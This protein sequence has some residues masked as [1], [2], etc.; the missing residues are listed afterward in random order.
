MIHPSKINQC[1]TGPEWDKLV[2]TIGKEEAMREWL[3][4]EGM[5]DASLYPK[6]RF[7]GDFEHVWHEPFTIE[8]YS[9]M[10]ARKK[11]LE[12]TGAKVKMSGTGLQVSR[13]P[14]GELV[15]QKEASRTPVDK[16]LDTRVKGFLNS[17]GFEVERLA[18]EGQDFAAMADTLNGI[19]KVVD[20]KAG[21][22]T[23]SHEAT[24]AFLDLLPADS[25]LLADIIKD[26]KTKEEYDQ[27][28]E[29]YKDDPQYKNEDGS[30]NEEKMA[31]E[32]AAHIIDDIIVDK[33]DQRSSMKWWERLWNWIKDMFKGKSL[34][35]Y[36]VVAE[37][38]LAGKTAKLS[39]EKMRKMK[40]ASDK[41]EIYY[42][43][44]PEKEKRYN[45]IKN[46]PE[47]SEKQK[48]VID[49]MLL[50][51]DKLSEADKK[52]INDYGLKP[53]PRTEL[54]PESHV[55]TDP[56]T[57][58]VY[59]GTTTKISGKFSADKQKRFEPNKDAGNAFDKIAETIINGASYGEI[60][61]DKFPMFESQDLLNDFVGDVR[62]MIQDETSDGSIIFAQMITSDSISMTAGSKDISVITPSGAERIIDLKTSVRQVF[63]KNGKVDRDLSKTYTS[64]WEQNPGSVFNNYVGDEKGRPVLDENGKFIKRTPKLDKD[65]N[66]LL[67][68][69]GQPEYNEPPIKLSKEMQHAIQTGSYARMDELQGIPVIATKTWHVNVDLQQREDG[70]FYI[71][72]Y[73]NEGML[74]HSVIDNQPYVDQVVPTEVDENNPSKLQKERPG[75]DYFNQ[76]DTLS[77]DEINR[78][79]KQSQK[80]FNEAL[81]KSPTARNISKEIIKIIDQREQ[82]LENLNR[83]KQNP[84]VKEDTILM[85]NDMKRDMMQSLSNKKYSSILNKWMD[86][87][88]SQ[89]TMTNTYLS[90]YSNLQDKGYANVAI[91]A[92]KFVQGYSYI[93]GL[94][95]QVH[96]T[97]IAKFNEAVGTVNNLNKT[98]EDGVREWFMFHGKNE[99]TKYLEEEIED[100]TKGNPKDIGMLTRLFVAPSNTASIPVSLAF[101]EIAKAHYDAIKH[102]NEFTDNVDAIASALYKELGVKGYKKGMYDFM[103]HKDGRFVTRTSPEYREKV[104]AAKKR[105]LDENGERKEYWMSD[106]PEAIA[107]NKQLF[108]DINALTNL[109]RAEEYV[110]AEYSAMGELINSGYYDPGEYSEY[111]PAPVY[112]ENG[113]I[114]R[115]DDY[116]AE[117][118][119]FEEQDPISGKYKIKFF[120]DAE[121]IRNIRWIKDGD[122][123]YEENPD[124]TR[125]RLLS[126]NEVRGIAARQYRSKFYYPTEKKVD[127]QFE[128]GK[129]TGKVK[130]GDGSTEWRVKPKFKD[131]RDVSTNKEELRDK[132]YIDMLTDPTSVG[133]A[134]WQF[135]QDYMTAMDKLLVQLPVEAMQS[136]KGRIPTQVSSLFSQLV[137]GD[138]PQT[139]MSLLSEQLSKFMNSTYV[140]ER[141][142]DETGNVKN[143]IPISGIGTFRDQEKIDRLKSEIEKLDTDWKAIRDT[144]TKSQKDKYKEERGL[145]SAELKTEQSK[146]Q[147]YQIEPDIVK[148]I[149][150]FA[151]KVATFDALSKIEDKFLMIREMAA[152]KSENKELAV[153]D[154][155]GR[156]L[157][158][159]A[160]DQTVGMIKTTLTGTGQ[161]GKSY[162]LRRIDDMMDMLLYKSNEYPGS[163]L[164][165]IE[166]MFI[167]MSAINLFTINPPVSFG[168]SAMMKSIHLT[169]A[170]IGQFFNLKQFA[171]AEVEANKAI[172]QYT[173]NEATKAGGGNPKKYAS[174]LEGWISKTQ[175]FTKGLSDD[176]GLKQLLLLEHW[177]EWTGVA[178]GAAA[179]G[180]NTKAV[181]KDGN[182]SNAYDIFDQLP[183]G[184]LEVKDNYA[185]AWKK[186]EFNLHRTMAD[187]QNRFHGAYASLEAAAITKYPFGASIMFL[188]KWMPAVIQNHWGAPMVHSNLG[189]VEGSYVTLAKGISDILHDQGTMAERFERGYNNMIPRGAV[190]NPDWTKMSAEE[191]Q[192]A[193]DKAYEEDP[194]FKKS[195]GTTDWKKVERDRDRRKMEFSN[196]KRSLYE[197]TLMI[198]ATAAFMWLKS[199]AQDD[200]GNAKRWENFLAKTFDKLRKQQ[201][202]A[203]PVV[204]LEEEYTLL[205]SPIA[206]LRT[207]GDFAQAIGATFGLVVPP[208]EE[209]Y[210][211]TGVHKGELKAKVKM[212]KVL[213]GANLY[214]WYTN[215]N[216]PQFFVK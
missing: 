96:G 159:R 27:V 65:G 78:L 23:L 75:Y 16:R 40:E 133:R 143:S 197:V 137:N 202:F 204:G 13:V 117:R 57:A 172:F 46:R 19:I 131:V 186:I 161:D 208:Y 79:K 70:S 64:T 213:P 66:P 100:Y 77:E 166:R 199:L 110:P 185:D 85:L 80:E 104:N 120:P 36:Q 149:N 144:A 203:M 71:K 102:W 111:K 118:E 49:A 90:D 14:V 183:D 81:D 62:K 84:V 54:E 86:Y 35:A 95:D 61:K 92:M 170:A 214:P 12:S 122:K 142:V 53:A 188:K 177:V 141:R 112:D 162:E 109:T 44:D 17:A 136:M 72:N 215:L 175:A 89:A 190:G 126:E 115:Y 210:Y 39:K 114:I 147:A 209:N 160:L 1:P 216:S 38:I 123:H 156:S 87:T 206:S 82:Y 108:E 200:E 179:I 128:K 73:R 169:Q 94:I 7:S 153:T 41:G 103:T 119:K 21:K 107:F 207:M 201:L 174:Y 205:K 76:T 191:R 145:K 211:S 150:N 42:E 140:S 34:D 196:M 58:E 192:K 50:E 48:A 194:N 20:G 15:Y 52:R 139:K 101:R 106:T 154:P 4:Q 2:D 168:V 173:S 97:Q 55:Y 148:G 67:R 3:S 47:T 181:G 146:V 32:A 56:K 91:Q 5:P 124:G 83:S 98:I 25:K 22:E 195:D 37:D 8:Q 134:K 74:Y 157:F 152:I 105:L 113:N 29:R 88:I 10:A 151:M 158:R 178:T 26:V 198:V 176:S 189:F 171:R 167:T 127:L 68:T 125:G 129:F 69:D 28:Y 31:K 116:V 135:Y 59:D 60:S 130:P 6:P 63:N 121:S 212:M 99:D 18:N 193:D 51:P 45:E 155:N 163:F 138:I 43:L 165:K 9:D 180:M 164:G 24:H 33:H 184:S 93:N 187:Y 182:I 30:V 132:K 11:Y